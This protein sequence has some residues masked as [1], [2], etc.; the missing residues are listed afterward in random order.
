VG[1][2][3][4]LGAFQPEF[5]ITGWLAFSL[6]FFLG[7]LALVALWR[8]VGGGRTLAWIIAFLPYCD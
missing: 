5:F 1:F 7:L 2:G 4:L 8:W 6:L 3:A